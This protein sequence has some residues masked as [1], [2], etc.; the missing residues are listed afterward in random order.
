MKIQYRFL[1]FAAALYIAAVSFNSAQA[2][3]LIA[4][5]E[6][7]GD[8]EGW[9][10][11]AAEYLKE[12]A[13]IKKAAQS[14]D[15]AHSGKGALKL[16]VET[17]EGA[18][19]RGR[20]DKYYGGKADWKRFT[21][22]SVMC[23]VPADAPAVQGVLAV[24]SGA[25]KWSQGQ[26]VS[27][28][29]GEWTKVSIDTADILH[30]EEIQ[31]V[32]FIPSV[33]SGSF[34]G[35]LHIDR[36]M[37][38]GEKAIGPSK[39]GP[40]PTSDSTTWLETFDSVEGW[41]R[42]GARVEPAPEAAVGAGA[43]TFFLPGF[44]T[45]KIASPKPIDPD[46]MDEGY[47]GISFWVKGDGSD[48]F[49]TLVLCGM[50]P[51]WFPFK[52]ACSFPLK[53]TTW[54][55]YKFRWDELVPEDATYSIGTPGG[56]P[57]SNIGYIKVGSKWNTTH[58]NAQMPKFSF[59]LDH[60]QLEADLPAAAPVPALQKVETVRARLAAKKPVSILCL[61]DSITAGTSLR[62]ADKERY[63]QVLEGMLR[64]RCGYDDI[65]VV[66]R[67]VGGAQGNDLRLW[68]H[69]DFTGI[70][71]DLV[72][73]MFGYNDKSWGYPAGYYGAIIKDYADRIARQ[74]SG[75]AALLLMPPIPGRGP[76]YIMM[77]DYAD[78]TRRAGRENNI[79]ICDIHA[80]FKAFGRAGLNEYMADDAHPNA[81]GHATMAETIAALL[82]PG[83]A[84]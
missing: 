24:M 32:M 54:K 75:K 83:T 13:I 33:P 5:W 47:A 11:P 16:S 76:R 4:D 37:L 56:A 45:K 78:A 44:I 50:H 55:Q 79:E 29:A 2:Q 35:D 58:N 70:E 15:M 30:P 38:E 27:C 28:K 25:W 1:G 48:Q 14:A 21:S 6:K 34:N 81:K 71:P 64:E 53:D 59:D 20:V 17:T 41:E 7:G 74:T 68:T 65:S 77:D 42:Q 49:G 80:V 26:V 52:Y 22:F 12:F 73:V 66:S 19:K 67:A 10:L 61:G 9:A 31:L 62:N 57:P 36:A 43:A 46:A 3:T 39:P 51:Q 84:R 60:L 82:V 72:I 23:H 63:A 69:R 8:T 40:D 18:S